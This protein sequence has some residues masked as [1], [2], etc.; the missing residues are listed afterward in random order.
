MCKLNLFENNDESNDN[1]DSN[2]NEF[3]LPRLNS[4]LFN[5]NNSYYL[6][7]ESIVWFESLKSIV[8]I[9]KKMQVFITVI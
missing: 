2:F 7:I 4:K 5:D 6:M 3:Q 1:D 9:L 8:R